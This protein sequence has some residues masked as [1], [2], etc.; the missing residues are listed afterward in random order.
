MGP[1]LEILDFEPDSPDGADLPHTFWE[2]E[3]CH[4]KNSCL[5]GE[6][7]FCDGGRDEKLRTTLLGAVKKAHDGVQYL[8]LAGEETKHIMADVIDALYEAK[9]YAIL[10]RDHRHDFNYPD[11][12]C[13]ICGADGRA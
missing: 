10:L 5:D 9:E 6:C 12:L 13:N 4:K 1:E 2:C 3:I 7:Q 11:D 8:E